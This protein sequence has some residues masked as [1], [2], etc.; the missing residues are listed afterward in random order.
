M[1]SYVRVL[2]TNFVYLSKIF[3]DNLL[4]VMPFMLLEA[5]VIKIIYLCYTLYYT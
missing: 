1:T 2:N 5:I 4:L 3:C